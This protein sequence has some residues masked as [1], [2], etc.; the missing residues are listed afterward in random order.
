MSSKEQEIENAVKHMIERYG[1]ATL[2]EVD[3]RIL[4]LEAR[5]QPEAL[6]L[7]LEIK[8]R[9]ELLLH[10]TSGNSRH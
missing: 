1:D 2:K 8:Q 9:V 7:W 4:E 6:E 10:K 3:L 5:G